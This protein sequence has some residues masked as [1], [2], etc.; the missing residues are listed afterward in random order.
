MA[1]CR[2]CGIEVTGFSW[3]FTF[4][5]QKGRCKNCEAAVQQALIRFREAFIQLSSDGMFTP[6]KFQYLAE[7]AANDFIALEKALEFICKD[8]LNLLDLVLDAIIAHDQLTD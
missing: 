3:L 7:K 4:N 6:Q 2:R 5:R 1:F 8:A